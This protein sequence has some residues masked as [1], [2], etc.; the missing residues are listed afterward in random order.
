MQAPQKHLPP[1]ERLQLVR[2]RPGSSSRGCR[3]CTW[4]AGCS[5]LQEEAEQAAPC[6]QGRP[7]RELTTELLLLLLLCRGSRMPSG[8]TLAAELEFLGARGEEEEEG[9]MWKGGRRGLEK[10]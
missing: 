8:P 2:P 5:S 6:W 3:G 1:A 9:L 7:G 4:P 10:R